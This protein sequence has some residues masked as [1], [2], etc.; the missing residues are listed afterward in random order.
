RERRM[1]LSFAQALD[2][3]MSELASACTTCGKCF[4]T[5]P[6]TEPVGISGT[7]SH[8]VL[9]GIVD[10]LRGGAGTDESRIWSAACTSSRLCLQACDYGVDPHVL[11]RM[12][13][14][15]RVRRRD[16]DAVKR[17]A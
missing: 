8:A 2:E 9:T 3:R 6:M 1:S 12:A 10:Q 4:E 7:D 14:L 15:A 11:V 17:N 13:N 16:G 5:C